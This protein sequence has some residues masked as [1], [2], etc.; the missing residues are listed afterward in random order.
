[1]EPT[2]AKR[3]SAVAK[4]ANGKPHP[5][6]APQMGASVTAQYQRA[7]E[8]KTCWMYFRTSN[9]PR[10]QLFVSDQIFVRK[11]LFLPDEPPEKLQVTITVLK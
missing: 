1:M 4:P 11:A 10:F 9:D 7:E 6:P 5:E 3:S 8:K 2:M